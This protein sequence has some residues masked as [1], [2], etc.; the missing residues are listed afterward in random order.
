M[1]H[2]IKTGIKHMAFLPVFL[3]LLVSLALP[4]SLHAAAWL[5]KTGELSLYNSTIYYSTDEYFDEAK[6]RRSQLRYSKYEQNLYAEYG[7]NRDLTIGVSA[8]V[9]AVQGDAGQASPTIGSNY[10]LSEPSLF[11]RYRL[12]ENEN[13]VLSVQPW[14]KLPS[15]YAKDSLPRG[16]TDQ[17]D[18]ELRLLGGHSFQLDGLYH[19]I[20]IE[21]A[22]RKRFGDPGDQLR[23]DLTAG[24]RPHENWLIMP[25]LFTTWRVS[26]PAAQ[27]FIQNPINDY[28]LIKPQLS[29]VY[30]YSVDTSFQLGVF[31]HLYGQNTGAGGGLFASLWY[32]L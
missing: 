8:S 29:A 24:F 11:A 15:L 10:G 31:K 20:N 3:W 2:F 25:Q 1:K 12:W 28:N 6:Q 9:D 27:R 23:F 13:S 16:G 21:A 18:M 32:R 7:W 22:Y 26:E 14:L 5:Q 17:T 19:F 30:R 4:F